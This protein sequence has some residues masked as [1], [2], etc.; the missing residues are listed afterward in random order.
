MPSSNERTEMH[1]SIA[2]KEN[3]IYNQ[4]VYSIE[5]EISKMKQEIMY[6]NMKATGTR[7]KPQYAPRHSTQV[8]QQIQRNQTRSCLNT[9]TNIFSE[10]QKVLIQHSLIF[11]HAVDV[12]YSFYKRKEKLTTCNDECMCMLVKF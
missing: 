6:M 5:T 4:A 9:S 3:C 11:L 12:W 2:T 1:K 7:Q 10:L 8:A